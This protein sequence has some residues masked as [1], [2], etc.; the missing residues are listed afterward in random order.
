M[1]TGITSTQLWLAAAFP[2]VMA[3]GGMLVSFAGFVHNNSRISDLK[4]DILQLSSRTDTLIGT[5]ND[6]DKRVVR[7]E[8]KLGISPQ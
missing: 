2:T 8:E 5:V 3:L 1:E 7:I 4:A 6:V